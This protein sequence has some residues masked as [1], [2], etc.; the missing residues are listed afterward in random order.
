LGHKGKGKDK[1]RS[2]HPKDGKEVAWAKSMGPK[3]KHG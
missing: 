3:L 1:I 2:L